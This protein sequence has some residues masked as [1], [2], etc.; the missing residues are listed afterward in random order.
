MELTW[1]MI[2]VMVMV[3]VMENNSWRCWRGL[4]WTWRINVGTCTFMLEKIMCMSRCFHF[5]D[6]CLLINV[7]SSPQPQRW[8]CCQLSRASTSSNVDRRTFPLAL[9]SLVLQAAKALQTRNRK[10]LEFMAMQFLRKEQQWRIWKR[11]TEDGRFYGH[12][13]LEPVSDI[14]NHVLG[15]VFDAFM[16]VTVA[17]PEHIVYQY[18]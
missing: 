15:S 3:M 7:Q 17:P 10:L 8:R 14:D 16:S 5:Q 18:H 13:G 11:K 6:P 12:Y 4:S 1:I 9:A 2:M